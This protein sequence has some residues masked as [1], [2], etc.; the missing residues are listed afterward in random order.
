MKTILLLSLICLFVLSNNTIINSKKS[1][2]NISEI[3]TVDITLLKSDWK[4]D[5]SPENNSDD[6]FAKMI[7]TNVGDN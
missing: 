1:S 5:L 4:P 3:P 2:K 6:N 7:I